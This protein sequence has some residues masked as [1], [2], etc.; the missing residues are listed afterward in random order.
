MK[1]QIFRSKSYQL[2]ILFAILSLGFSATERVESLQMDM[3]IQSLNQGKVITIRGKV[4]YRVA[5][6]HMVTRFIYPKEIISITNAQGEFSN[7]DVGDNVVTQIQGADFSSKQSFLYNFLSGNYS[8]MGLS[9]LGFSISK[10]K[11]EDG[12]AITTWRA[13]IMNTELGKTKIELAHE[14]RFPIYM[15][16]FINDTIISKT[17]YTNAHAVGEMRVPLNI[18]EISYLNNGKD[19]LITRKKYFNVE[20]NEKVDQTYL[21]YKIPASAKLKEMNR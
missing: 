16:V 5:N 19:S 1:K 15:G 21:N 9:T 18:T 7:Y 14:N 13:P 12:L 3:T 11:I 17:Y 20:L 4:Y 10:S 8:D 2:L 6:G